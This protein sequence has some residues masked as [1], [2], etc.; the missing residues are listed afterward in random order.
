M[1]RR[2]VI[3]LALAAT[4]IL[5]ALWLTGATQA[6]PVTRPANNITP[7]DARSV[8][9]PALPVPPVPSADPPSVFLT[10]ARSAVAVGRTGEARE[11]LERAETR[12]LDRDLPSATASVPNNQQAVLAIGAARRALA[13]HDRQTAIT[14][15]NDALAAADRPEVTVATI[16][17]TF[18]PPAV[19]L[20]PPPPPQPVITREPV[21]TR[22][23]LPGHWALQGARY[24]WVSPETTLRRVQSAGLVPGADVWRNGAYVWVPR[25]YA[26]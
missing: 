2:S 5:S 17:A 26:N 6:Q 1:Q 12:L 21:I 19:P 23:L 20:A 13:A 24:V 9:A 16:P 10:A 7:Y 4:G 22:A 11:A 18:V 3:S 14:A 25:H 8:I 15:V